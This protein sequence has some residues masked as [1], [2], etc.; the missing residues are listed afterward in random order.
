MY[1]CAHPWSNLLS[2]GSH[3]L[4][5]L[6]WQR[7]IFCCCS[8]NV[9]LLPCMSTIDLFVI[10]V[11]WCVSLFL[12]VHWIWC[13]SHC[14]CL[15]TGNK[16]SR[17][18]SGWVDL[19]DVG[20]CLLPQLGPQIK[21]EETVLGCSGP[22]PTLGV[23]APSRSPFRLC[24]ILAVSSISTNVEH[25]W[26]RAVTEELVTCEPTHTTMDAVKAFNNEVCCKQVQL[27]NPLVDKRELTFTSART[28]AS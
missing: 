27:V 26:L 20:P 9:C 7:Y 14:P 12:F 13:D 24:A 25:A 4:A 6:C 18:N 22:V 16:A 5:E 8:G 3:W 15:Y 28:G 21:Q 19:V 2:C 11:H 1:Y 10:T 17:P 23:A